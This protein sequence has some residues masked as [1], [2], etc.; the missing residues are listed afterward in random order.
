MGQVSDREGAF[1][2]NDVKIEQVRTG[3]KWKYLGNT[4]GTGRWW[5]IKE[6]IKGGGNVRLSKPGYHTVVM[7]ESEFLQQINIL[8]VPTEVRGS[9]FGDAAHSPASGGTGWPK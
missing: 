2:V 3:G 9:E 4:D 5:I 8:M 1:A 7:S 6:M